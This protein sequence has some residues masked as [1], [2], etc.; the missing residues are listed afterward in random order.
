MGN[1]HVF[2]SKSIFLKLLSALFLLIVYFV[3][4]NAQVES[5][6]LFIRDSLQILNSSAKTEKSIVTLTINIDSNNITTPHSFENTKK[7]ISALKAYSPKNIIIMMEPLDFSADRIQKVALF[8]YFQENT[9][10]LNKVEARNYANTF[11]KD[12]VFK[13]YHYYISFFR[14]TDSQRNRENRRAILALDK[15]GESKIIEDLKKLGFAPK[16]SANFAYRYKYWNSTQARIKSYPLGTYG[17]LQS[18]DLLS[19]KL[20]PES[21][22]NKTVVIGTNDEFSYLG[23]RSTFELFG[24]KQ[25]QDYQKNWI[26]FSEVFANVASFH[27]T[28]DYIKYLRDFD[29]L[30]ITLFLLFC[31]LISSAKLVTKIYIFLMILPVLF[32]FEIAIYY[33]GS[34]YVDISRSLI[35]LVIAQY[36]ILPAIVLYYLRKAE[37]QKFAAANNARIDALLSVSEQIAHD[38]R[39]PLSTVNLILTKVKFETNEHRELISSSIERIS[40]IADNILKNLKIGG[41]TANDVFRLS[42]LLN[43]V[44]QEKYLL[45]ESIFYEKKMDENISVNGNEIAMS[46]VISNIL[47][48]SIHALKSVQH[49]KK[50]TVQTELTKNKIRISINDNGPGIPT[51]I[52]SLLGSIRISTKPENIGTGIGLLSAKRAVEEMS[53]HFNITSELNVGTT[54]IIEFSNVN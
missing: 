45:D 24:A 35:V 36:F 47:D 5:I 2:F 6:D 21:I 19:G 53:G 10:Y 31:I 26:P 14:C 23:S 43:N 38:I 37:T 7:I 20:P 40:L 15:F 29:D 11:E 22:K 41:T 51:S 17:N 52:L 42:P 1:K 33:F 48:N 18:K 50:I 16:S 54:V 49:R 25:E 3:L 4:K 12:E 8:K 46:R 39:S 32:L 34:F 13:N 44:L 30:A 27:V 9:I 28:G